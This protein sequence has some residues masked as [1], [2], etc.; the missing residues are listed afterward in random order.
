[1]QNPKDKKIV[2]AIRLTWDSLDS[3]LVAIN[4]PQ[5]KI[6]KRLRNVLGGK[7]FDKQCVKEYAEILKTLTDL[8]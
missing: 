4:C 7:K 5:K 2:R 6:P 8:L 3:H 1:M